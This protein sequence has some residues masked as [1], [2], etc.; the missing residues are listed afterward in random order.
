[1]KKEGECGETAK[2][3]EQSGS[4]Q[5]EERPVREEKLLLSGASCIPIPQRPAQP[6]AASSTVCFLLSLINKDGVTCPGTV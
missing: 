4:L 1:M 5:A 6:P 2:G 3:K